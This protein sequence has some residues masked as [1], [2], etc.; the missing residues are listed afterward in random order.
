VR[1]KI[2]AHPLLVCGLLAGAFTTCR[3]TAWVQVCED[4]KIQSQNDEKKLEEAKGMVYLKGF[5]EGVMTV[6][7][8]AGEKVSAAKPLIR[9]ELLDAGEAVLYAEPENRVMSRSGD[10]CVVALTDQWCA[11]LASACEPLLHISQ[12][13]PYNR[14][15][16]RLFVGDERHEVAD[17]DAGP[18]SCALCY[19]RAVSAALCS[20]TG[21][22]PPENLASPTHKTMLSV[23][24]VHPNNHWVFQDCLLGT[25]AT[26]S[27]LGVRRG[28][29]HP[30][31]E[32]LV[33]PFG[34]FQASA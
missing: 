15:L 6:G 9:Q 1:G 10:E 29:V 12:V 31:L 33:D 17:W 8:Y 18:E 7:M 11:S 14:D 5:T 20:P 28:G 3:V 30:R 32:P 4:L 21:A 26:C 24:R 2:G 19:G 25:R 22:L 13:H 23:F 16:S 27:R 34:V